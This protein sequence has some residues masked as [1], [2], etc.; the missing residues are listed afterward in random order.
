MVWGTQQ[1]LGEKGAT[2]VPPKDL[3]RLT[4]Q[5]SQGGIHSQ[6]LGGVVLSAT[7]RGLIGPGA[8]PHVGADGSCALP[9]VQQTDDQ[10]GTVPHSPGIIPE[11]VQLHLQGRGGQG[12]RTP[13]SPGT[14]GDLPTLP[15]PPCPPSSPC[16]SPPSPLQSASHLPSPLLP[17]LAFLLDPGAAG[18]QADL[19]PPPP[20]TWYSAVC[21]G[22]WSGQRGGL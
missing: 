4:L 14:A 10:G 21:G 9:R 22:S 17:A 12:Q 11:H 18:A 15:S 16:P 2:G 3:L 19:G 20:R 1:L 8:E 5:N 7:H 6:P 13:V